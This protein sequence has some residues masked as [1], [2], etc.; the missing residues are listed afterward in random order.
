MNKVVEITHEIFCAGFIESNR[1]GRV[2]VSVFTN[3][4]FSYLLK[5]EVGNVIQ[6]S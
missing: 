5:K 6:I 3:K 4:A 2:T 1:A